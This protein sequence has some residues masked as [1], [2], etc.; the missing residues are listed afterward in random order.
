MDCIRA[1]GKLCGVTLKPDTP[2]DA[3]TPFLDIADLILVMT[4]EPG[5]G[6][7][8]FMTEQLEKIRQIRRM[9]DFSGRS[10]RLEADGGIDENTAPMC[11]EAGVDTLVAGTAVFGAADRTAAV[12]SI[13]GLK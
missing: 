13:R 4:V 3:V 10:I 8:H 1:T 6:G 9:I 2:A 5:F 11:I 7:Q 12:S